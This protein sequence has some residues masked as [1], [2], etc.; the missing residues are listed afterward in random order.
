[1]GRLLQKEQIA[2]FLPTLQPHQ[3]ATHPDGDTVLDRAVMEHNLLA[4]S[5]LYTNIAF[6]ELGQLLSVSPVKA[7]TTA[8]RMIYENRMK[9][10]IDQVDAILQFSPNPPGLQIDQW[11]AHIATICSAVDDCVESII[12]KYPQF[13]S[14]LES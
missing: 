7:E 12:D 4:V 6:E 10:S 11:D 2:R 1:M 13:A 9:A 5:R 3:L 14:L 8:A